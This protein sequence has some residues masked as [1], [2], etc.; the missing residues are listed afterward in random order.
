MKKTTMIALTSVLVLSQGVF[1]HPYSRETHME[2]SD[3]AV[4]FSTLD[5][6]LKTELDFAQGIA[7]EISGNNVTQWTI[8]GSHAED[9]N[10]R[11]CNHFHN[12]LRNWDDAGLMIVPFPIL[13]C[14]SINVSSVIWGQNPQVQPPFFE[15]TW[16]DARETFFEGLKA[17]TQSDRE[18][19]F[20][21]TLRTLGHLI[22][23][24]Q[25][26]AQ[27][28]HTRND[29]HPFEA[30]FE[31]FV[32]ATLGSR[33]FDEMAGT[34]D[35]DPV[36]LTLPTNPRAPI[37]IAH[38]ID[39]IDSD[40]PEAVPVATIF[41]GLAEYSNANFL[42]HD[43]VFEKFKFPQKDSLGPLFVDEPLFMSEEPPAGRL[44]LYNA[45]ISEG[46][47][48]GHF[49]ARGANFK[50]FDELAGR[51][52]LGYILDSRVF[53]DYASLLLPR[54]IGFSAGLIDYFIRGRMTVAVTEIE[55]SVGSIT[56]IAVKV[57]NITP[58][59]ESGTGQVTAT[60]L[61]EGQV[62]AVSPEQTVDLT[63]V[64][65]ELTFD[66][67]QNA[68][69]ADTEDLFLT[70]AYRG[71]LGLEADAVMVK[72]TSLV[73]PEVF[74]L[75]VDRGTNEPGLFVLNAT[76]SVV[77]TLPLPEDFPRGRD[78]IDSGLASSG[79]SLFLN[80]RNQTKV[81]E[82]S[83]HT[84]QVIRTFVF[85]PVSEGLFY[86]GLAFMDGFLY[87]SAITFPEARLVKINPET[88]AIV[89]TCQVTDG[90]LRFPILSLAGGNGRLFAYLAFGQD[91]NNISGDVI[92]SRI[93]EIDPESCAPLKLIQP[94]DGQKGLAFDGKTLFVNGD[95][96]SLVKLNPD[97]D[98]V[99]EEWFF[100]F[101][102]VSIAVGSGE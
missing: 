76:G 44:R 79:E 93:G 11:P 53:H 5:E 35:F 62:V 68:I 36:I 8:L 51:D 61:S 69:P 46:E 95:S 88:G 101:R 92:F 41:Q 4:S 48:V 21:E 23:L 56:K 83:T 64:K 16:Q 14:I 38:L 39:R 2:L 22:H 32:H 86:Q 26:A 28:A 43:T 58:G 81:W 66:F 52:Y 24:V 67:S 17:Q 65:Q 1:V 63:N 70:V 90:T 19:K 47:G 99:L 27:P 33:L 91:P 77:R 85:P 82:L 89:K 13:P 12:P 94:R 59:E 102:V 72:G 31:D 40:D 37:P 34:P 20:A 6:F 78:A 100:P 54:A 18:K 29:A 96:N 84:G 45:K 87:T 10:I 75:G 55:V 42:S 71:P 50:N 7:G 30:P 60:V 25:D 98:E 9:D 49:V 57:A 97:T 74:V 3:R 15:F 80:S 73:P